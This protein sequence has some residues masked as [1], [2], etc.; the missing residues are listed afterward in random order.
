MLASFNQ[1]TGERLLGSA[2]C[3]IG[4]HREHLPDHRSQ[5]TASCGVGENQ[6]EIARVACGLQEFSRPQVWAAQVQSGRGQE[7]R[8]GAAAVCVSA[9][10]Q[11]VVFVQLPVSVVFCVCCILMSCYIHLFRQICTH[12][13]ERTITIRCATS[14]CSTSA[15]TGPRSWYAAVRP[16]GVSSRWSGKIVYRLARCPCTLL[17]RRRSKRPTI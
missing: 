1:W 2:R 14:P 16:A 11:S 10:A 4:K 17:Y 7:D 6:F 8:Q 15:A 9:S 5:A 13:A 12:A 3:D